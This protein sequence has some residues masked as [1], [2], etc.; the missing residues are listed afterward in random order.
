MT[1]DQ[2]IWE[3]DI[4][5]PINRRIEA[6]KRTGRGVTVSPYWLDRILTRLNRYEPLK[7][8]QRD[9]HLRLTTTPKDTAP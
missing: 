4:R 3:L 8:Y 1:R 9:A 5:G 6:A 2:E 7:P